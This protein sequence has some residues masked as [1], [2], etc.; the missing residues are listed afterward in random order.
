MRVVIVSFPNHSIDN[1]MQLVCQSVEVAA[2]CIEGELDASQINGE[3]ELQISVKF[4]EMDWLDVEQLPEF[5][6][7]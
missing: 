4:K 7:Y 2:A 1:K 3:S 5:E 6:G